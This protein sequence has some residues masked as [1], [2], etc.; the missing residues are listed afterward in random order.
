MTVMLVIEALG[1]LV[2]L[3]CAALA[4]V[5]LYGRWRKRRARRRRL[6]RRRQKQR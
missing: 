5:E 1:V 4:A 2:A 6:R 3:P